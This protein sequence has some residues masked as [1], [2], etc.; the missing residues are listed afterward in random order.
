MRTIIAILVA[1]VGLS[2]AATAKSSLTN[3]QL[4][5]VSAGS[6]A[7]SSASSTTTVTATASPPS[8][9]VG[10]SLAVRRRATCRVRSPLAHLHPQRV[11]T[12]RVAV[13]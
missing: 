13:Q 8:N 9:T 6:S 12:H 10:G 2:T 1:A 4:D 3:S 5:K 11:P 7:S